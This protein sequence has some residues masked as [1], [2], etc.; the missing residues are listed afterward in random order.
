LTDNPSKKKELKG[1]RGKISRTRY[2]SIALQRGG[3]ESSFLGTSAGRERGKKSG[4]VIG[5]IFMKKR[6]TP[7]WQEKTGKV[8]GQPEIVEER[9]GRQRERGPKGIEGQLSVSLVTFR[10]AFRSPRRVAKASSGR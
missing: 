9:L 2:K 8:H 1:E 4:G 3:L 10:N 6:K 5:Q 7:S